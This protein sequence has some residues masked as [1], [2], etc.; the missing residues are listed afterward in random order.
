MDPTEVEFRAENCIVTIVPNFTHDR[1]YLISGDVGP[2]VPSIPLDVPL[3][4]A[5][6]LRIRQKCR[7]LPPSWMAVERLEEK[8]QEETDSKY[9]TKMPSSYYMEV[10]NLLLNHAGGD[11]PKA[12]DI[13]TLVK[14]IWD[15][16]MAKLR[17]SI[18][19]FVRSGESHAQL[20]HLTVMEINTV[21]KFLTFSLDMLHHMQRLAEGRMPTTQE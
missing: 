8:K 18:D 17:S 11:I 3:W 9:F 6:N 15:L 20:D 10:A 12:D 19:A 13:R 14:D 5:I 21:R 7:L 1:L 4:L 16:R 2:F